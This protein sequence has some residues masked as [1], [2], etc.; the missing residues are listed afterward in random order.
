MRQR[1][2]PS[3]SQRRTGCTCCEGMTRSRS[4]CQTD[5]AVE[6]VLD[7]THL[8]L[9]QY[10]VTAP[11]D[12]A[13]GDLQCFDLQTGECTG[14]Y[15]IPAGIAWGARGNCLYST[16]GVFYVMEEKVWLDEEYEQYTF[17]RL[18]SN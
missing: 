8:S 4:G 7:G 10:L 5:G 12:G 2:I 1:R 14:S 15:T 17:G 6:I 9:I 11:L 3:W 18:F 16:E 13:A